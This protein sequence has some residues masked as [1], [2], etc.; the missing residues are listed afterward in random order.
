[1]PR[2]AL[3]HL[4]GEDLAEEAFLVAE[5][6]VEHPLV[7]A[8]PAGDAI[9]A[10]AR[11]ALLGELAQGR[12]EDALPRARGMPRDVVRPWARPQGRAGWSVRVALVLSLVRGDW[13]GRF[14][15]RPRV[16]PRL[17]FFTR[18]SHWVGGGVIR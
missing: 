9:D 6:M 4:T 18:A 1:G 14:R 15:G 12:R 8:R 7:D 13:G 5:V 16:E 11:E 10:G 2:R 3:A 17:D